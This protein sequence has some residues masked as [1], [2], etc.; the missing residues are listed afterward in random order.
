MWIRT[1]VLSVT[2]TAVTA[3]LAAQ[4]PPPVAAYKSNAEIVAGLSAA[5][6][7]DAALKQPKT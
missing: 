3:S 5:R 1:V 7:A 2:L 6:A 4:S